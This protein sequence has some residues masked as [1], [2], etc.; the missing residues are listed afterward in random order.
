MAELERIMGLAHSLRY[1]CA[2]CLKVAHMREDVANCMQIEK[3][4]PCSVDS[5]MKPIGAL[6]VTDEAHATSQAA[7]GKHPS[8]NDHFDARGPKRRRRI[9]RGEHRGSGSYAEPERRG[10]R[11][12]TS[13]SDAVW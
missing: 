10:R 1:L 13:G 11:L 4:E 8:R 12:K 9:D 6:H 5:L 7:G 2:W 3:R